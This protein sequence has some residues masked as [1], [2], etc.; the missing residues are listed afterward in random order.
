M[1]SVTHLSPP[2]KPSR[3]GHI[4]TASL[5]GVVSQ[6]LACLTK[7]AYAYP[8]TRPTRPRHGRRTGGLYFS[9]CILVACAAARHCRRP[10]ASPLS[11]PNTAAL[12]YRG[13][14][15][16][17]PRTDDGWPVSAPRRTC[18]QSW[19]CGRPG[20]FLYAARH[21]VGCRV[22]RYAPRAHAALW[23]GISSN[24]YGRWHLPV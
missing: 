10:R 15:R 17:D 14:T 4:D 3:P 11:R 7:E 8:D 22:S 21:Q 5:T 19:Q 6:A 9:Q 13:S 1:N 2:D 23:H 24:A 18:G 20:Y 12:F 16:I